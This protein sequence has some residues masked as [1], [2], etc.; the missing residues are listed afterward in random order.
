M[1][2]TFNT[3]CFCEHSHHAYAKD[4]LA[5][6]GA[7]LGLEVGWEETGEWGALHCLHGL[8]RFY[9]SRLPPRCL[10]PLYRAIARASGSSI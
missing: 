1:G 4:M 6:G 7:G 9:S 2:D 8:L 3:A 10:L 5:G